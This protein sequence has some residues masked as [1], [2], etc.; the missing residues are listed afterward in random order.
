MKSQRLTLSEKFAR[1]AVRMKDPEWRRYALLLIAG[2]MIGISLL[3]ALVITLPTLL[4]PA[5]K[6][7]KGA[8]REV[9]PKEARVSSGETPK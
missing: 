3:M 9:V 5:P 8:A 4:A 1:L 2:K 6:E 7:A